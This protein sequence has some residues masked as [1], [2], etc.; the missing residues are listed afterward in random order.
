MVLAHEPR[1][2]ERRPCTLEIYFGHGSAL[3]YELDRCD[4]GFTASSN[5]PEH[6]ASHAT[7]HGAG[8]AI[9]VFYPSRTSFAR[10]VLHSLTKLGIGLG[11][12]F[13]FARVRGLAGG[14]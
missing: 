4:D 12:G 6:V 3:S 13:G 11:N 1:L 7:L 8:F 10:H 5:H 2:G 9:F 14:V